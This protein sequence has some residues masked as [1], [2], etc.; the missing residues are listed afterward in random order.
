M[1]QGPKRLDLSLYLTREPVTLALLTGLAGLLLLAVTGLSRLYHAQQE[2]LAERWSARGVEDLNVQRFQIAVTDFRTALLYDR[3]NEAYQLSLAQ[4]LLGLKR[5]DEAYAYLINL[6]DRQPEN[7]VVNLELARIAVQKGQTDRALRFY[8]NAIYATWPD[9]QERRKARLELI[10]YLFGIKAR[11]Q[12]ESELIALEANVGEDAAQ[13]TQLGTLFL[14]VQDYGRALAAF[15]EGMKLDPMNAAA[16]AGAGVAAFETGQ[17]PMAE[18]Y[19][20]RAVALAPADNVSAALLKTTDSVLRLD[21]FRPQISDAERNRIVVDAFATAGE[22]LKGCPSLAAETA[23]SG[24][25]TPAGSNAGTQTLSQQWE[26]LKPEI[27]EHG[28]RRN[29]DL[30]NAAM[31]LAFQ[32]ERHASSACGAGSQVDQA[33]LLIANLHEES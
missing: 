27:T 15:R 32:I 33:I 12:A 23:N 24:S 18:R 10:N 28:L 16:Y 22:R 7:G 20:A 26:K 13:Q 29:P 1:T 8:H 14:R 30:V 6:W 25:G 19:L 5:T 3:D 31:N 4:A 9:F 11:T 17:Y 2:S 21:P